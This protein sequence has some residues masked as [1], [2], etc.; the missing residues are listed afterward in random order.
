M[1][2]EEIKNDIPYKPVVYQYVAVL[3]KLETAA[4][5]AGIKYS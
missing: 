1:L 3:I 5:N 2:N 4:T